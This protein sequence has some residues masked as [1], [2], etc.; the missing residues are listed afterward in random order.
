MK[1]KLMK[2]ELI[3]GFAQVYSV[4]GQRCVAIW[5]NWLKPK[6]K[7]K[8]TFN[9][10]IQKTIYGGKVNLI[11]LDMLQILMKTYPKAFT[12]LNNIESVEET[13]A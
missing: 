13:N 6:Q 12:I 8:V 4:K 3:N 9:T 10:G 7:L 2:G 11:R 1:A 5:A